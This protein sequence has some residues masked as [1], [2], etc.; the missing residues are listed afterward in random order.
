MEKS[1]RSHQRGTGPER[2]PLFR[3]GGAIADLLQYLADWI[4]TT[5][6]T[7]SYQEAY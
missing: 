6:G 2:K 7:E 3:I 1:K 5:Q 4:R